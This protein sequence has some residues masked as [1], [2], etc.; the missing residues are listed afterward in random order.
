MNNQVVSNALVQIWNQF[1]QK[2][3]RNIQPRDFVVRQLA[4]MGYTLSEINQ[5]MV[6]DEFDRLENY[7]LDMAES[8]VAYEPVPSGDYILMFK[9]YFDPETGHVMTYECANVT[10]INSEDFE[11]LAMDLFKD[12]NIDELPTDGLEPE[13]TKGSDDPNIAH[14]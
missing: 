12:T 13:A 14:E 6:D 7:L 2:S 9:T 10:L 4:M 3:K 8:D 5:F 1:S 11:T